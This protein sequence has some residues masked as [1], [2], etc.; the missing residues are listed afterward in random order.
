MGW[1]MRSALAGRMICIAL[2]IMVF[3]EGLAFLC[4]IWHLLLLQNRCH[5]LL[6]PAMV[7]ENTQ[8]SGYQGWTSSNELGGD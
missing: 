1:K 8:I 7:L 3:K 5:D 6:G 2:N 4:A